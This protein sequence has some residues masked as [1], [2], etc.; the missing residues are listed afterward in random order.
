[1]NRI[2]AIV[3]FVLGLV[4]V[5]LGITK[6]L[7]G[8]A[9]GGMPRSADPNVPRRIAQKQHGR[10]TRARSPRIDRSLLPG[11]GTVPAPH[12]TASRQALSHYEGPLA[13]WGRSRWLPQRGPGWRGNAGTSAS[14]GP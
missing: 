6:I 3:L 2:A 8:A 9:S 4:L 7:P 11:C 14:D 5:I 12:I 10:S 13:R 1:M